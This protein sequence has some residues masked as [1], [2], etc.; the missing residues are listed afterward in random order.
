MDLGLVGKRAIVTGGS[1]G[2]GKAIASALA[3]EGC[4]LVLVARSP[5]PLDVAGTRDRH[6]NRAAGRRDPHRHR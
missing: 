1:R 6:R 3:A 5:E 2:I 4:D